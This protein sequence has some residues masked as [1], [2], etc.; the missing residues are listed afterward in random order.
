MPRIHPTAIVHRDARLDDDIEIGPYCV[1]EDDV[2]I[3]GG[4]VLRAH[5]VVRSHTS[6]GQRNLVESF[7]VLGGEPQDL[8]FDSATV[9]FLRI[10]DDNTFREGVTISRAT[11]QGLATTVG[12]RTYWMT[13][14]H[15][16]HNA[17]VGD[18]CILVNG[19]VLA[20][21]TMLGRRVILSAHIGVHQFC[22]IGEGAMGQGNAAVT[23]HVPPYSLFANVN[24]VVGLNSVGLRRW[25]GLTE[26][27]RREV[28]EVFAL[29]YRRGLPLREAL[30]RMD[31][32]TEWGVAANAFR[33]FIR[34]V[35]SASHPYDR[36]LCPLRRRNR[37]GDD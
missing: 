22:W 34:R 21:Y 26:N 14:T 11:G 24:R 17:V 37:F 20:G 27:D 13:G 29:T 35:V 18:E 9:S 30:T 5:A 28:K 12:S 7:A 4:S 6:L 25:P 8:K 16:G 15:A 10:G 33:E 32:R 2:T 19:A 31:E 3:G 1:V 36:G 23:M